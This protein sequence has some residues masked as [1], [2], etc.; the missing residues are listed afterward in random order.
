MDEFETGEYALWRWHR[1]EYNLVRIVRGGDRISFLFIDNL[2]KPELRFNK[3]VEELK[4]LTPDYLPEIAKKHCPLIMIKIK[5]HL[6][7]ER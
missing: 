5:R 1:K 7:E 2:D 3:E 6:N 4:K